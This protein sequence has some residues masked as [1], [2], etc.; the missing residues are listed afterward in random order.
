MTTIIIALL[1]GLSFFLGVRLHAAVTEN[2]QLR[3]NIESLKR[4]LDSQR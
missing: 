1:L 3:T 4:R 2:T